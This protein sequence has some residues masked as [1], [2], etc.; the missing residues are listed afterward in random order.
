MG[1]LSLSGQSQN[2]TA[3]LHRWHRAASEQSPR[4]AANATNQQELTGQRDRDIALHGAELEAQAQ[5]HSAGHLAGKD[6]Q[7]DGSTEVSPPRSHG[8]LAQIR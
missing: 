2:E 4:G 3:E 7:A 8:C 6:R 5:R 1:K